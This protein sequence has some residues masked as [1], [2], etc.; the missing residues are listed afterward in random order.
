LAGGGVLVLAKVLY[1]GD[2][3]TSSTLEVGAGAQRRALLWS[4]ALHGQ[5]IH[6]PCVQKP[7]QFSLFRAHFSKKNAAV[8]RQSWPRRTAALVTKTARRVA[9][10]L[11][12]LGS[13]HAE[14]RA[15]AQATFL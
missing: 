7:S 11:R 1:G 10:P 4:V 14:V 15:P 5:I 12:E 2:F 6:P 9:D 8:H 13:K 3:A